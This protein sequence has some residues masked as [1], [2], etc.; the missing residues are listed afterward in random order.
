MNNC[1]QPCCFE[2]IISACPPEG[3]KVNAKLE[4]TTDYVWIITD[5][6]GNI[7]AIEFTTDGEGY[8]TIVT[9]ELPEGFCNPYNAGFTIQVKKTVEDCDFIPLV[10]PIKYTCINVKMVGGTLEKHEIGC[11]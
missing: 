2:D 5:Q 8:G 1:C 10:F 7:Y 4:P 3:I 9:A 6:H 11:I